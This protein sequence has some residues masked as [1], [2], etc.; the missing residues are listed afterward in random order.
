MKLFIINIIT[1]LLFCVFKTYAGAAA[2]SGKA[3]F[4]IIKS[5]GNENNFLLRDNEFL[6][7]PIQY[8]K[9]LNPKTGLKLLD[10]PITRTK[11][12]SKHIPNYF[13]TESAINLPK[14]QIVYKG[15]YALL[16]TFDYALTNNISMGGGMDF[17][18]LLLGVPVVLIKTKGT[19]QLSKNFYVG[20][21]LAYIHL[22]PL[23][24]R[25]FVIK[26]M[27]NGIYSGILT[28]GNEDRNVT[29][30]LG[31]SMLYNA[32]MFYT[33]SGY[34]KVLNKFGLVTESLSIPG[35]F[36][37]NSRLYGIGVRYRSLTNLT[38]DVGIYGRPD[39]FKGILVIPYFAFGIRF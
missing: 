21:N 8:Q 25:N 12:K 14:G 23:S 7:F 19:F 29:I 30:N 39:Y 32:Q 6:K 3:R 20:A 34:V 31:R 36:S 17:I 18:T 26:S 33:I 10:S 11:P 28:Y 37:M 24:D 22:V 4:D 1:S 15:H 9:M 27:G 38:Y 13:L 2:F 16:H 35:Y 5:I